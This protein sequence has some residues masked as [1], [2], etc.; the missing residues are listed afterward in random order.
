VTRDEQRQ[1]LEAA[2]KPYIAKAR[3]TY[4][5]AKARYLAGLP[6]G[7]TFFVTVDLRDPAGHRDGAP[8]PPHETLNRS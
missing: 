7:Q 8:E 3:A 4:P 1:R 2:L 6:P 5:R